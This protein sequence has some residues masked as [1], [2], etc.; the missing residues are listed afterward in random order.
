MTHRG[1]EGLGFGLFGLGL[2]KR[3]TTG[4]CSV[5]RALGVNTAE[6]PDQY[7][8][9]VRHEQG[10]K[11]RHAVTINRPLEDL[12][13]YFRDFEN[14]PKFMQH[15]E[16][17]SPRVADRTHWRARAPFGRFVEWDAEII[18][19]K[20]NELIAWRSL[21][22]A[23]VD[24]AGSVSFRRAPTGRGTEVH[25]SLS[26]QPPFGRLGAVV[27]RLLGE[28]PRQQIEADLRHFKQL[29]EAGEIP[30][31]DGQPPSRGLDEDPAQHK[32]D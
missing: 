24:S 10:I 21:P 4:H 15:L 14:L 9:G 16:S 6:R 8:L 23:D 27:A 20:P 18:N 13:A 2:L 1:L 29:M 5:Y 17:V 19:D 26:Y 12:Y 31:I 28:E 32:P 7:A 25:V 30:T 3:A 11:V 22:G